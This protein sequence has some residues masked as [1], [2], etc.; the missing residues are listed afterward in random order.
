MGRVNP[1]IL[2]QMQ[3]LD[4]DRSVPVDE[5]FVDT[6]GGKEVFDEAFFYLGSVEKSDPKDKHLHW[7]NYI[8]L[9]DF[10]RMFELCCWAHEVEAEYDL[11]MTYQL[12]DLAEFKAPDM[13]NVHYVDFGKPR[14]EI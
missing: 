12:P 4:L 9:Q 8:I 10:S 11:G 5:V 6:I 2:R 13:N 14:F 7:H 3:H 1:H